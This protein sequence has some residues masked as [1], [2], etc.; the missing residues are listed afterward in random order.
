M[1]SRCTVLRV[2]SREERRGEQSLERLS[3]ASNRFF[4]LAPAPPPQNKQ[5]NKTNNTKVDHSIGS[6]PQTTTILNTT[7]PA[8]LQPE[9]CTALCNNYRRF[10]GVHCCGDGY[11]TPEPNRYPCSCLSPDR[12]QWKFYRVKCAVAVFILLQNGFYRG[13]VRIDIISWLMFQWNSTSKH[14]PNWVYFHLK[15]LSMGWSPL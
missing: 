1:G 12:L 5:I 7:R 14:A 11:T 2:E 10:I 15:Y 8:R 3:N 9:N 6:R 4:Q 13:N